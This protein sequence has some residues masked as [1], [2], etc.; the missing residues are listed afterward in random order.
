MAGGRRIWL[1]LVVLQGIVTAGI[2]ITIWIGFNS[3]VFSSHTGVPASEL[4]VA[5]LGS[6]CGSMYLS[7]GLGQEFG[8]DSNLGAFDTLVL[9][10]LPIAALIA[11]CVHLGGLMATSGGWTPPFLSGVFRNFFGALIATPIGGFV[12]FV[13]PLLPF[14][15]LGWVF[16]GF[17]SKN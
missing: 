3:I 4:H 14:M 5:L 2:A 7:I 15:L 11:F 8:K 6:A 1:A 10:W 13:V 12:I 9:C 16:E 17:G